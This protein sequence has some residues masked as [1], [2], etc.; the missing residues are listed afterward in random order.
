M[1]SFNIENRQVKID[2]KDGHFISSE[3]CYFRLDP[4]DWRTR[5]KQ[6][7]A[8]GINVVSFY[9]PWVAHE[10]VKGEFDFEGKRH[11]SLNLK[12]WLKMIKEEG[13][14]CSV[15][16]G[17]YI[18]NE[19]LNNGIPIWYIDN[20]RHALAAR[21]NGE[22]Y[23][24]LKESI[25]YNHPDLLKH[26]DEWYKNVAAVLK[27]YLYSNGG[28]LIFLQLDNET[29]GK[30]IW[31]GGLDQNN[32]T[33]GYGK[34]DGLFPMFLKQKY[35]TAEA[36]N[37]AYSSSF[38]TF[39]EFFPHKIKAGNLQ[40]SVDEK[41]FQ[42]DF[43]LPKFFDYLYAAIRKYGIDGYLCVNA[44]CPEYPFKLKPSIDRHKDILMGIDL[45]YNFHQSCNF[46]SRTISFDIEYGFEVL[47]EAYKGPEI[48][49]EMEAGMPWDYPQ[50]YAPH[51]YIYH[52]WCLVTGY[53]GVNA[54]NTVGGVNPLGLGEIS[55]SIDYQSPI[56]TDGSFKDTYFALQKAY[57]L[58]G[59]DQFLLHSEK[60]YDFALG[61][62]E[63][64]AALHKINHIAYNFN[65]N[66]KVM[67]LKER[68]VEDLL[69]NNF[70]WVC[71][72]M[73]LSTDIQNK[74]VDYVKAGG[75]LILSGKLPTRD[76]MGNKTD[77][78][79]KEFG[80]TFGKEE[81]RQPKVVIGGIEYN[82]GRTDKN[83]LAITGSGKA[84][85][86]SV[87]GKPAIVYNKV[88]KGTV[89]AMSFD[90]EY[91]L[92]DQMVILDEI[93]KVIGYKPYTNVK[94]NNVRAI[95]RKGDDGVKRV[96]VLNYH[97]VPVTFDITVEGYN[98]KQT[99]PPFEILWYDVVT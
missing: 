24:L 21:W 45:Y 23:S 89:V 69:K 18:Y 61:Y 52:S 33:M 84:L 76:T 71:S 72:G 1:H 96:Y 62:V 39:E 79:Q 22:K 35:G 83:P 29:P 67:Y 68:P 32:E 10:Y 82:I 86:S 3:V 57:R 36:F 4:K 80:I 8:L 77:F 85:A 53:K 20:Y 41:E 2:G 56:S 55:T 70:I 90:F 93:F 91:S 30:N 42:Y 49:L 48:V 11:P 7:K 58:H 25:S 5:L 92:K 99:M 47:S 46:D 50:V 97:P 95:V 63:D 6:A 94:N 98:R 44:A 64:T 60:V 27:E 12:G 16:P 81:S 15:R 87:E 54:F 31:M 38:K 37:T 13:L 65:M 73:V 26:V 59:H 78:M 43:Y 88:G 74:L 75:K 51:V 34:T 40:F 17:P 19:T 66:F 9:I 14:F 28:P